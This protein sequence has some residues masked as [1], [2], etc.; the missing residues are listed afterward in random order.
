ME[1]TTDLLEEVKKQGRHI[2]LEPEAKMICSEY[3]I[4][5]VRFKV[6]KNLSEALR[7]AAEI[8]YPVVLKVISPQILHKSEVG[9]VVPNIRGPKEL[10]SAYAQM[11]VSVKKHAPDARIA[12]VL[13][14]EMAPTSTEVIVGSTKDPQ[15]GH[16]MMFGLGGIFVEVLK[17][18]SF[19]VPPITKSD[20]LEMV[21]EIKGYR[22]LD[23]IRNQPP[24]DIGS[25][26]EILMNVS[27]LL[28]DH[29]ELKEID[30]NPII[31]YPKGAKAVDARMILD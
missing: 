21:K 18:V 26:V 31:V 6:A 24:S 17:D 1:R 14:E 25:L 8:G 10:R 12:G 28:T 30:L 19:R 13:V 29:P 9:G 15:F 20:A 11:L 22:V 7:L 4:P 23:G 5:I 2:L 3:G 27:K 16:V